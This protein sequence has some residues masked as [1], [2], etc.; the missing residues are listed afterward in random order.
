M[1]G[2]ARRA[3]ARAQAERAEQR[4]AALQRTVEEQAAALADAQHATAALQGTLERLHAQTDVDHT[5]SRIIL[6]LRNVRTR[7][8]PPPTARF[9][10][11]GNVASMRWLC[12]HDS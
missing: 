11:F 12:A 1:V 9:V 7:L 6:D 3:Q 5:H 10:R 4:A 2:G 8:A